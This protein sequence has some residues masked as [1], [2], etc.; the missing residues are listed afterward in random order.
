MKPSSSGDPAECQGDWTELMDQIAG[1]LVAP[2]VVLIQ[3]M[4]GKNGYGSSPVETVEAAL[5]AR[6]PGQSWNT[7]VAEAQPAVWPN[8]NCP[9]KT[10]QTNGIMYR[11]ARL[12]YVQ[13]TK[14]T[15]MARINDN[16]SCPEAKLSRN[17]AVFAKFGDRA[18]GTNSSGGYVKEVALGSVHWPVEDGCG[19]TNANLTDDVMMSYTGAQMHIWGGDVNLPDRDADGWMPWYLRAN[20]DFGADTLGYRD[21]IFQACGGQ[22]ACLDANATL[23]V[24]RYDYLFAKYKA[25]YKLGVP[26][27][28]GQWTVP[29]DPDADGLN[30]SM[31]KA[32]KSFIYW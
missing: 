7:I 24:K 8:A 5:A 28:G 16:G 15:L 20:G 31:H 14:K 32:V 29:W 11:T 30:Y 26:M 21:P 19:V 18:N 13:N 10:L 1:T 6:F 3:Q 22:E 9:A 23:K 4:S 17:L 27:T 2:D 12:D 25:S